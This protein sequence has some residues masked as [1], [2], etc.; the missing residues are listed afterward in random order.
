MQYISIR[1]NG[2][3]IQR[4]LETFIIDKA[5]ASS[6]SQRTGSSLNQCTR[7][8]SQSQL[9][10]SDK[11][12]T[13]RA[14]PDQ[15]AATFEETFWPFDF[16]FGPF[17]SIIVSTSTT[18]SQRA[19]CKEN[20]KGITKKK[21]LGLL[22]VAAAIY[23]HYIAHIATAPL[24]VYIGSLDIHLYYCC[25]SPMDS[26][27]PCLGCLGQ[28]SFSLDR[29]YTRSITASVCVSSH[30]HN[31]RLHVRNLLLERKSSS[32]PSYS[33]NRDVI[34]WKSIERER[35]VQYSTAD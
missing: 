25:K 2:Y 18:K 32:S 23:Y 6:S 33:L 35:E 19:S 12:I 30:A 4:V 11:V 28:H 17:D 13:P 3:C 26:V 27:F 24:S 16:Y 34:S 9:Q 14:P 7:I 21:V 20:I 10:C 8:F 15:Q 22:L 29:L 31:L 1:F 5:P